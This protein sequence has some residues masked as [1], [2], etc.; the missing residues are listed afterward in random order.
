MRVIDLT[1]T[2][3]TG[4]IRFN[5]PWHTDTEIRQLGHVSDVGRNTS[6]IDIGSHAGTHID[7]ARHFI[8]EG[9]CIDEVPLEKLVGPVSIVDLSY[10][11]D[12]ESIT[13]TDLLNIK[14]TPRMLFYLGWSR[15]WDTPKFYSGYPFFERD[16]AQYLV[17][18]GAIV[19]GMDTPSPDDSSTALLS[20]EDSKIHKLFL[21]QGVTII[22]Y[23][24]NL[25]KASGDGWMLCA[26]PLKL[27]GCDGSPSRVCIVKTEDRAS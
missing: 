25:D 4:M 12:A 24:N 21:S 11:K 8:N 18:N 2:V 9:Q 3:H 7:A 22:E 23:L 20:E 27:Q 16:A 1:H 17:D 6:V 15:Y 13:K 14:I 26:L 10:K 19:V 5:A